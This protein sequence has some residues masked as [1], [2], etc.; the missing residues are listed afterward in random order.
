MGAANKRVGAIVD[1]HINAHFA[2]TRPTCIVLG[3]EREGAIEGIL[4]IQIRM[5]HG[6][7]C[8]GIKGVGP[9]VGAYRSVVVKHDKSLSPDGV[10]GMDIGLW[11][12]VETDITLPVLQRVVDGQETHLRTDRFRA[13]GG[14]YT[15]EN[16]EQLM[17]LDVNAGIHIHPNA[18]RIRHIQT[19]AV[20]RRIGGN[21]EDEAPETEIRQTERGDFLLVRHIVGDLHARGGCH[22]EIRIIFKFY[23]VVHLVGGVHKTVLI[24]ISVRTPNL[25]RV[26]GTLQFLGPAIQRIRSLSVIRICNRAGNAEIPFRRCNGFYSRCVA[27]LPPSMEAVR[28]FSSRSRGRERDTWNAVA[29]SLHV[30]GSCHFHFQ[31][32]ILLL[33]NF[34]RFLIEH[35]V[36]ELMVLHFYRIGSLG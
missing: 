32:T 20:G 25:I 33:G 29:A 16:P 17:V 5:E 22:S 34:H 8:H 1:R 36:C 6:G 10:A 35:H 30:G 2:H 27:Y 9:H 31:I 14:I 11:I 21:I 26:L 3:L 28:L 18:Q 13:S 24:R 4:C 12:D 19:L 7:G 15:L 23:G